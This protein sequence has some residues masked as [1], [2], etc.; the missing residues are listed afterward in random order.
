M[1]PP[2]GLFAQNSWCSGKDFLQCG[3]S[4]SC[5]WRD[6][7]KSTVLVWTGAKETQHGG[8]EQGD[9]HLPGTQSM[10]SLMKKEGVSSHRWTLGSVVSTEIINY[11]SQKGPQSL[12]IWAE[13]LSQFR[14]LQT[15]PSWQSLP[16][17]FW[18]VWLF[19]N[20]HVTGDFFKWKV[21]RKQFSFI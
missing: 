7:V 15:T 18:V 16:E 13:F 1:K 5:G 4:L 11:Q 20:Y 14:S 21:A 6:A 17:H 3:F 19:S 8:K 2:R 9:S 12:A 10:K